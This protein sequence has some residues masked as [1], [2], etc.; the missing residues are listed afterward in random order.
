MSVYTHKNKKKET[1]KTDRNETKQNGRNKKTH[2]NK[3]ETKGE[4]TAICDV[5]VWVW[6]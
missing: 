1:Y 2:K 6:M 4:N 3:I 5:W